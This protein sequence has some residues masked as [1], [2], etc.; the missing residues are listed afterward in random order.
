MFYGENGSL[1]IEEGNS[2]KIFDVKGELIKHKKNEAVIDARNLTSPAQELDALHI[3]NFF[4]GIRKGSP[5]NSDITSGHKSTLLVQLGNIAFRSGH[6]LHID[7]QDGHILNDN[8]AVK[9]WSREYEP[10]WEPTI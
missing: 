7:P 9:Y 4:D 1:L 10:G 6:T 3:R 2:Y 8:D 5:L